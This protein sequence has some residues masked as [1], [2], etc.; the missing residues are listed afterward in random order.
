MSRGEQGGAGVRTK[1]QVTRVGVLYDLIVVAV[2]RE[3]VSV[4]LPE[5][6]VAADKE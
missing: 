4:A 5:A 6:I 2:V 3:H 1:V